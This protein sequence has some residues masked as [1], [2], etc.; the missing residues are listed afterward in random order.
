MTKADL[1]EIVYEKIGGLSKKESQDIVEK[2]FETMKA[3]L[4]QGDK[5]KISGFGNFTLRDKRPT[6]GTQSAD[7]RRHRNH[8][9]P[10]ADVPSQPDPEVPH[11]RTKQDVLRRPRKA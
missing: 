10:R 2:I 4:K 1:V 5:I 9:A 3:S 6:E 11:Q 7:R 8:R